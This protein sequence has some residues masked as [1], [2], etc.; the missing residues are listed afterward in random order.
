MK[1]NKTFGSR[2]FGSSREC[3]QDK[4]FALDRAVAVVGYDKFVLYKAN[5]V[6]RPD[7]W[8]RNSAPKSFARAGTLAQQDERTH[9]DGS[10]V[11]IDL[12]AQTKY[13]HT[14]MATVGESFELSEWFNSVSDRRSGGATKSDRKAAKRAHDSSASEHAPDPS[15]CFMCYTPNPVWTSSDKVKKAPPVPVCSEECEA[16]YLESKGLRP[17][18]KDKKRK[19]QEVEIVD[20]DDDDDDNEAD[21]ERCFVCERP[22]PE[23]MSTNSVKNIPSVPVCGVECE[24]EHLKRKGKKK[25]PVAVAK[26]P[27]AAESKA[28]SSALGA[29]QSLSFLED[30]LLEND[31]SKGY[32]SWWLRALTFYD[33][34][35]QRHAMWHRC[36]RFCGSLA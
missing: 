16:K 7:D 15:V 26:K 10:R 11:G 29:K 19:Q 33:F 35:Y 34:V 5:T 24:A 21:T 3:K 23:Y 25:A 22:N 30:H 4:I 13:A 14:M 31:D 1:S 6:F 28:V 27:K 8:E 36:V 12:H 17:V 18:K 20:V 32:K 9:V 2:R